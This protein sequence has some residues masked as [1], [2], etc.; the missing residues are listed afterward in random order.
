MGCFFGNQPGHAYLIGK[1]HAQQVNLQIQYWSDSEI[2]AR[3]D[4]TVSG[5]LDQDN[6]SLVI[7]PAQAAQIK[8]SGFKFMAA[9]SDPA[10]LLPQIPASWAKLQKVNAKINN[11]VSNPVN[12]AYL[13]PVNRS[14]AP[15]DANGDSAYVSREYPGHQ[16][17][18][19]GDVYDFSHLAPGWTTDSM[20]LFSYDQDSCPY[21][22]TYRHTF[23]TAFSEW[24]GDNIRVWWTTTSCSG[25]YPNPFLGG[26]PSYT[27]SNNTGLYYALNVWVRGPRCTDPHTGSA[28]QK[29]MQN[30]ISCGSENCGG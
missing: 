24:L 10:V 9:R 2:D 30:V 22:L 29:C 18:E 5:E 28:Q 19:G 12:P 25:F 14:P 13:S 26:I 27:Y 23:G 6:V 4:P 15:P 21:V 16:F 7:A 11:F 8:A 17:P 1:F 20:Q 3:V